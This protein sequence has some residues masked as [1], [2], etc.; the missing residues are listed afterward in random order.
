MTCDRITP[1]NHRTSMLG[2]GGAVCG[3]SGERLV[4]LHLVSGAGGVGP[5][6]H[7]CHVVGG[8]ADG[9]D[10]EMNLLFS[11]CPVLSWRLG[12][13]SVRREVGEAAGLGRQRHGTRPEPPFSGPTHTELVK[14]SFHR[15]MSRKRKKRG[16]EEEGAVSEALVVAPPSSAV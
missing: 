11:Q 10:A 8:A 15:M 12:L 5:T 6:R 16:K 13:S 3:R 1:F 14:H 7:G 2:V 9:D 4:H